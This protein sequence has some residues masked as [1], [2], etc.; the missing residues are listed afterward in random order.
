VFELIDYQ[1]F[2]IKNIAISVQTHNTKILSNRK[3]YV[4]IN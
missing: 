3:F 4:K 1:A 2:I